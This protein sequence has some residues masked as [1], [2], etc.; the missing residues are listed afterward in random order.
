MRTG[1]GRITRLEVLNDAEGAIERMKRRAPKDAVW[2]EGAWRTESATG[3]VIFKW[4]APDPNPSPKILRK[5][6]SRAH[7]RLLPRYARR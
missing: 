4:T 6:A 3:D 5:G 7:R 1:E 2:A